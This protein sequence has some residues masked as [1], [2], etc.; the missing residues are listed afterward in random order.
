[1]KRLLPLLLILA[2]LP[3]FAE[4]VT[5]KVDGLVC[6]YCVQGI[7]KKFRELEPVKEIGFDLDTGTVTLTTKAE[8]DVSDDTIKSI[9][10]YGG[11]KLQSITRNP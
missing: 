4:T 1:M 9:I 6:A 5:L 2:P 10:S 8:G 3:A 7:E 11:Y